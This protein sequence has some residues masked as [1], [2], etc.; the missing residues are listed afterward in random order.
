MT[1]DSGA[2]TNIMN[3]FSQVFSLGRGQVFN[4]AWALLAILTGL[5]LSVASLFWLLTKDEIIPVFIKKVLTIGLFI[6]FVQGFGPGFNGMSLSNIILQGFIKTGAVAG[7]NA[8]VAN[9]MGD[10]SAIIDLGI[11]AA[12]PIFK[13]QSLIASLLNSAGVDFIFRGICGLLILFTYFVLAIQIVITNIEFGIVSTLGLILLPFGVFRYTSFLADKFFG[14][15]IAFGIKLMVLAFVV[16]VTFP[17]LQS[18]TLPSDPTPDQIISMLFACAAIAFIAWHAPGVASAI[19]AGSPSLTA[20]T[21][22]QGAIAGG[23][24]MAGAAAPGAAGLK[25]ASALA[26]GTS[27]V[28]G[29]G[30]SV[31]NALR[32]GLS[33]MRGSSQ[34][35]GMVDA[36]KGGKQRAT[37]ALEGLNISNAAGGS[38]TDGGPGNRPS[39]LE[40]MYKNI[41]RSVPPEAQPGA[42]AGVNIKPSE[43]E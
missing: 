19:L 43:E 27:A 37:S 42:G 17:L 5:E 14:A 34:A 9:V 10:P 22:A 15:I 32:A 35:S 20:G 1:A 8:N 25:G 26:G 16:G 12:G 4:Y 39:P 31:R 3:Q 30:G 38:K 6:F 29:G 33:S 11:A 36:Y 28:A 21:G 41:Q 40:S 24:V 2:L 23:M 7:G 13:S 18:F